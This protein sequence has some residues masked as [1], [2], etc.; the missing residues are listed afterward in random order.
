MVE[1]VD[2]KQKEQEITTLPQIKEIKRPHISKN[3]GSSMKGSD[4]LIVG[5]AKSPTQ[6]SLSY[7]MNI[8]TTRKKC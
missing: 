4:P 8:P 2:V 6:V 1:I 7:Y 5:K 3:S